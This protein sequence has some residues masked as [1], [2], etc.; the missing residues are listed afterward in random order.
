MGGMLTQML[1]LRYPE[2]VSS[3]TLL[4]TSNFASGLPPMEQK[5]IDFFEKEQ[6]NVDWSNKQ[7][8]VDMIVRRA[9]LQAGSKHPFQKERISRIAAEE[10]DRSNAIASMVNHTWITGGEEYLTRTSEMNVS[11]L[12]IHGTADPVI[13]YQHG[14]MLAKSIPQ[15]KLVTLE[16]AGHELHRNDWDKII[17][18]IIKH[19]AKKE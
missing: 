17:T 15:A 2:R 5:V 10:W 6:N 1:A 8:V 11:T 13:P 16:G 3:I 4:A 19:T 14:L 18:S 7:A 12:V 9:Q